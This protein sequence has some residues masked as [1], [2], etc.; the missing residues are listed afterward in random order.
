MAVRD[1]PDGV[2]QELREF[3]RRQGRSLNSCVN[4][5]LRDKVELEVRRRLMRETREEDRRYRATL[6]FVGDSTE[7]I[8][9]DRS[10][11]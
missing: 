11:R 1:A 7:L 5:I 4:E 2:Y 10:S 6:P 3:A 9:E 8:R